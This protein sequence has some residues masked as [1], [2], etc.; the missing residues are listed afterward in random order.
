MSP[1]AIL[2]PTFALVG[3]VFIVWFTL[4]VQRLRHV[5]RVPPTRGDF[6]TAEA[7]SRYFQPVEAPAQNLANLFEMPVLFLALVPLLLMTGLT[8]VAQVL[9]AWGYVAARGAHSF[10]HLGSKRV[11]ARFRVYLVSVALLSA[12]WIGFLIDCLVAARRLAAL[13]HMVS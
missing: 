2:W 11:P 9:L 5:R 8:S 12:M 3:L 13:R 1:F 4:V 10:I 7:A 6:A